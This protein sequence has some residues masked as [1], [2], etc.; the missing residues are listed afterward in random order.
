MKPVNFDAVDALDDLPAMEA[1]TVELA[2][3]AGR[4]AASGTIFMVRYI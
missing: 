4:A 3:F 2:M 1:L